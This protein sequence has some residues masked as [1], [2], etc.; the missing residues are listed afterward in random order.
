MTTVTSVAKSA[1]KEPLVLNFKDDTLTTVSRS[2]VRV[3]SK[4]LGFND[5][6]TVLYAL[7]RLRDEVIAAKEMETF[8][9]L[10][11]KQHQL[12]AQAAPAGKGKIVETL[13]P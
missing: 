1:T 3:L 8:M 11:K 6:Q 12:I 2:T 9:P 13:L 10:T 5:T 4:K 7:A